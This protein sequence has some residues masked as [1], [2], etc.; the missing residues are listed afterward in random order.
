MGAIVVTGSAGG[1]GGAIRLRVEAAG[2]E[3]VGV[4]VA[5][6]EVIADLSSASGRIDAIARIGAQ[7]PVVDGLVVAAGIGGSTGVPS[8]KVARINYFGAVD[9]LNGLAGALMGGSLRSAVVIGSNSAGA[10]PVTDFELGELCLAGEEDKAASLADTL[11]GELVY[12]YTKLALI[13]KARRLAVECAPNARINVVAP[14]PVLTPLTQAALNHPTTGD[15]IR[16]FPVPLDRWGEKSEIAESVWFLLSEQSAWTTG[17][18]LF[19]D[20][21]TDAL[22]NPD[23]L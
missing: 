18:V 12:A 17:S 20:G 23:R 21:G 10:V 19:V 13:R 7:V 1:I 15:A 5:E 4:D 3:V 8:A 6:S 9:L 11:D 16:A 22:L 14:G 2:H